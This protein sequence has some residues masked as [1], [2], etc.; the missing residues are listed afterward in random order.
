M[1]K[2][3]IVNNPEKA[4]A[5]L[6]QGNIE[7]VLVKY[8]GKEPDTK[9]DAFLVVKNK[10]ENAAVTALAKA[11]V[12]VHRTKSVRRYEMTALKF[13][14]GSFVP[15]F[16]CECRNCGKTF[17]HPVKEAAWCSTGCRKEFYNRRREVRKV[18]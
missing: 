8:P 12:H 9:G 7:H 18:N 11:E 2:K 17:K 4:S 10:D 16:E 6:K 5:I 15:E 14:T 1:A 13:A 3:I